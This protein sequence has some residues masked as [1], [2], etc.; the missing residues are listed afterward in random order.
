LLEYDNARPVH[1]LRVNRMRVSTTD[2]GQQLT[3][4]GVAWTPSPYLDEFLR[5]TQMQAVIGAGLLAHGQAAVQDESAGLVSRILDP[6]P[7]EFIIDACSAP[8]GKLIHAGLLM[9]DSGRLLGVDPNKRRLAAGLRTAKEHGLSIVETI[10]K[11]FRQVSDQF[12][13]SADAVLVDAPCSGLG[14]LARRADLRWSRDESS[15][16]ELVQLQD[17]L[18]DAAA[19]CVRP[20]GRLV[21]ATCTITPEENAER[22]AAFLERHS[23]FSESR[24]PGTLP[25]SVVR[26]GRLETLPHVHGID[27]AFAVCLMRSN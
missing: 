12:A 7:G 4:L 10:A 6:R 23:S 11:D 1:S 21:Y 9:N 5:V 3:D 26:S 2:F 17:D 22:V 16:R 8:C 13:Q 14:V 18:L 24:T 20:G 15:I 19:K 25:D 27:G